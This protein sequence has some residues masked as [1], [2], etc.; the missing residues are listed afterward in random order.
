MGIFG[1]LFGKKQEKKET[2][3]QT[4]KEGKRKPLVVRDISQKPQRYTSKAEVDIGMGVKTLVGL[5]DN[6]EDLVKILAEFLLQFQPD[7]VIVGPHAGRVYPL[8]GGPALRDG[9]PESRKTLFEFF[10]KFHYSVEY[11]YEAFRDKIQT[12][13]KEKYLFVSPEYIPLFDIFPKTTRSYK[14]AIIYVGQEKLG[15]LV[16]GFYYVFRKH[17]SVDGYVSITFPSRTSWGR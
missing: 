4:V 6:E 15:E 12:D 7:Q 3:A 14:A 2:K 5:A 8:F 17:P 10:S 1:K 16:R 11:N 9:S 13:P